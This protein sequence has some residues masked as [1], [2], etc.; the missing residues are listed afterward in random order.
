[1][2]SLAFGNVAGWVLRHHAAVPFWVDFGDFINGLGVGC[3]IALIL[4]G[5][6]MKNRPAC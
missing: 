4:L 3:S 6:R 2:F 5:L 1:M